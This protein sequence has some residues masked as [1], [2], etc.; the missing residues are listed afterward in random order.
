MSIDRTK[1]RVMLEHGH[2]EYDYLVVAAGMTHNYFGHE[3][4]WQ[5]K[6]PGLKSLE[7]ATDI[8]RRMLLAFEAAEYDEDVE[9]VNALL[10]FV[11]V[12]GGPTG[13]EM[14]GAIAEIAWEVMAKDFRNVDS[15]KARIVLIEGQDRL[16]AAMHPDSSKRALEALKDRGVEIMLKTFVKDIRDDGVM[17]GDTFIEARTVVWAAGLK[18]EPL[19]GTMGAEQDRM[20]RVKITPELSLPDDDRVYVLGDIAHLHDEKYGNVLPGL[21]PVAIQQGQH[22]GKNILRQ[23][24]GQPREP[25]VYFDKGQMAT[26]GR[27]DAVAEAKGFQ[28]YGFIAWLAW[29]FIHVMF[30]I[31][32]RNKISVMLNWIYAYV[33]FRRSTRLIVNIEEHPLGREMLSRAP[34]HLEGSAHEEDD[35]DEAISLEGAHVEAPAEQPATS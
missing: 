33:A 19:A 21:A 31:G 32:F 11:I 4:D 17:A 3:G 35:E 23:L 34:K 10:T 18:A 16:L 22:A 12:G 29:L 25:F 2:I 6:A 27:A 1:R 9:D 20:G 28:L 15:R 8:R 26:I 13:V 24:K 7:E 5:A 30:L 14:A